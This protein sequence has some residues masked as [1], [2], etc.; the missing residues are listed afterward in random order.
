MT[1]SHTHTS[2]TL[3]GGACRPCENVRTHKKFLQGNER[4]LN[5][6]MGTENKKSEQQAE[7]AWSQLQGW[8]V[9]AEEGDKNEKEIKMKKE[10]QVGQK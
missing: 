4:S 3:F 7:H 9:A 2:L 8:R 6:Y 1:T 5:L 10:E